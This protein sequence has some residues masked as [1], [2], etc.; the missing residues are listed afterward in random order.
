M[1]FT[2]WG[3]HLLFSFTGCMS[4]SSG[5]G[6]STDFFWGGM[7]QGFTLLMLCCPGLSNCRKTTHPARLS[8][9][10]LA[11]LQNPQIPNPRTPTSTE[12]R[13]N[14]QSHT[15]APNPQTLIALQT[16]REPPEKK[17]LQPK[18][19]K[20]LG[21]SGLLRLGRQSLLLGETLRIAYLWLVGNGGMDYIYYYHLNPKL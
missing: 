20:P 11:R 12:T 14:P 21:P 2:A 6:S 19:L 18:P 15:P 3:L 9:R 7:V 10:K 13:R 5:L 16:K 8:D 17:K 1:A 4:S